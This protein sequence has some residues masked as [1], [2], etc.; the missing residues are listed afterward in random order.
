M[1]GG[2]AAGGPTAAA[3]AAAEGEMSGR[4]HRPPRS[5]LLSSLALCS[6]L[7]LCCLL[8]TASA[9]P[10]D[11][12]AA[13]QKLNVNNAEEAQELAD[14]V[15]C[16]GGSFEV[17]WDSDVALLT[18]IVVGEGTRLL[19]R[20]SG[21]KSASIDG[22]SKRRIF[23]VGDAGSLLLVDIL[24]H[25][26]RAPKNSFGGAIHVGADAEVVCTGCEVRNSTADLGGAMAFKQ[27]GRL[28]MLGN[29]LIH[30]NS[31]GSGG[32]VYMDGGPEEGGSG[33][34]LEMYDSASFRANVATASG[35]KISS[36][37]GAGGGAV[38]LGNL[39]SM[40]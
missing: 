16:S 12:P 39:C 20:G 37:A 11:C 18:S 35:S 36:E 5:L 25:H 4:L 3:A 21:T 33:C 2:R 8:G 29:A 34:A 27:G 38:Q 14:A 17:N 9:A 1:Q 19:V 15:A 22:L 31:A 7:A 32:A 40:R 23:E 28:E 24:L 13:V 10:T 30:S 26:G 6:V